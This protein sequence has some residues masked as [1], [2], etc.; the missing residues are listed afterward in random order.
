METTTF[1]YNEKAPA[2]VKITDLHTTMMSAKAPKKDIP[3]L[4]EILAVVQSLQPGEGL[5]VGFEI[6]FKDTNYETTCVVDIYLP[7]DGVMDVG[8]ERE[9]EPAEK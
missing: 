4:S 2:I 8:Q 5:E 9:Y 3:P 6:R 1:K 7:K